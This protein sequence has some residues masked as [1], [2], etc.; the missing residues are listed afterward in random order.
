MFSDVFFSTSSPLSYPDLELYLFYPCE[1]GIQSSV[2]ASVYF[3]NAASV[4]ETVDK[5]LLAVY[6]NP[7]SGLLNIELIVDVS[8]AL[9]TK[10][11]SILFLSLFIVQLP[12]FILPDL[13]EAILY[14]F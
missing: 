14:Y 5:R 6:P 3:G 13:M 1:K 12:E 4:N 10:S 7:T 8:I 2:F 9:I 11:W